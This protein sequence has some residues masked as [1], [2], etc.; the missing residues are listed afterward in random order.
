M[1]GNENVRTTTGRGYSLWL[2][3]MGDLRERLSETIRRLAGLYSTPTFEPHVTLIGG[4]AMAEEEVRAKTRELSARLRPFEIRLGRA[5]YSYEYFQCLFLRVEHTQP[6]LEAHFDARKVF[7]RYS[8]P[9][10]HPHL[11]LVYGQLGPGRKQT[12]VPTVGHLCGLGF[13]VR[14][15]H[16]F[17]TKGRPEEWYRAE[18]F[19]FPLDL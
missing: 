3:P 14:S 4:L 18:E 10:Y 11:S 19:P 2:M 15:L 7:D 17:S 13:E 1:N 6:L 16:L 5:D 9:P 8:D 12:I